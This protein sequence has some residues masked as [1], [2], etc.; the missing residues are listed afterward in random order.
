MP[1]AATILLVVLAMAGVFF[2]WLNW[3]LSRGWPKA[4]ARIISKEGVSDDQYF[5]A[6][7]E[8][9]T[10]AGQKVKV[11]RDFGPSIYLEIGSPITVRVNPKNLHYCGFERPWYSP[12]PPLAAFLLSLLVLSVALT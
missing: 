1:I 5:V 7:L 4:T 3:G 9:G 10:H 8:S 6:V 11:A 2:A 12:I